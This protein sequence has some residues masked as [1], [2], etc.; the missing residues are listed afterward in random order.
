MANELERRLEALERKAGPS[1][2]LVSV[3]IRRIVTPGVP[4]GEAATFISINPGA[5]GWRVDRDAGETEA[6]FLERA[7]A[8]LPRPMG[9]IARLVQFQA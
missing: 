9:G 7:R 8:T 3:I 5:E 4:Q 2:D 1:A 6:A